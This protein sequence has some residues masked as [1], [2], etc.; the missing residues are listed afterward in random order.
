MA[1]R[2]TDSEK[3]RKPFLRG[4]PG[5][6]KLLWDYI[7]NDCNHAGI[8]LVDFDIAQICVGKDMPVGKDKALR[9]L[10]EGEDRIL[11]LENGK[12][13]FIIPFIAFQY[14]K[15]SEKNPAH[16]N[17][18]IELKKYGL[19]NEHLDVKINGLVSKSIEKNKDMQ[20]SFNNKNEDPLEGLQSTFKGTKETYKEKEMEMDKGGTGGKFVPPTLED[21]EKYCKERQNNVNP[22]KFIAH[23]AARGWVYSGNVKMKNWKQAVITWETNNFNNGSS[24][25][26]SIAD[27]T[28][29]NREEWGSL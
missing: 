28:K 13:W 9:L 14:G 6:Y 18:I 21:V 27:P 26:K 19:I 15:L 22:Q 11:E 23:Y 8:W 1:K 12:K 5:A 2:F 7:C 16:K 10:N 29:I 24:N 4:L 25:K 17:I 3:Y 20:I